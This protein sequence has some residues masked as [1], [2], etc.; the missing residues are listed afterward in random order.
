MKR[1]AT[2]MMMIAVSCGAYAQ[3]ECPSRLGATLKPIGDSN[4]M[5]STEIT[6]SAGWIKNNYAGN[7]MA[8]FG[9]NYGTGKSSF[10]VE[11]GLK[12]W[13]RGTNKQLS[14]SDDGGETVT[15]KSDRTSNLIPGLRE[16]FYRY[17]GEKNT[18]TIGLQSAKGDEDYLLNERIVGANYMLH[19]QNLRFNV[20]GGSVL[21]EFARNGRFCSLGYLYNDIVVGRPRSFVGNGFGDTNFGMLSLS[22]SP[23]KKTDEF[24]TESPHLFSFD[25][26]GGVAYTE[27]GSKID[28]PVFTGGLFSEFSVAGIQLKPEILYQASKNNNVV[29]YNMIAEKDFQWSASQTT[30]LY[31]RY[32][33]FTAVSSGARPMNSFSNLFM[34]DMLRQDVLENPVIMVGLK[35]S[36]TKWKT[37]IKIQGIM[38]TKASLLGGDYGF[39]T[40]SYS[41]PLTKMKELDLGFSK[42]FG[43]SWLVNATFGMLD[44]PNLE[45]TNLVLHY[46]HVQTMFGRLEFRFTF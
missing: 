24:G 14:F 15:H 22:F 26:I 21:Q 10:Y 40:D 4:F 27:F 23:E 18:F 38:Q 19:T 34:G 9:L 45:L 5:W 13:V 20:I 37:S 17:S 46:N 25:K 41:S 8:F 39:V 11:G 1:T 44:Y 35:H 16:A 3:W 31:A 6:T 33:G 36:F 30:R 2:V 32:L 43:K 28:N 42:N 29:I 12:A 7:A